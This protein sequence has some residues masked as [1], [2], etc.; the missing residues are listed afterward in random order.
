MKID[1]KVSGSLLLKDKTK[2][3]YKS[4]KLK[5]IIYKKQNV[6]SLILQLILATMEKESRISLLQK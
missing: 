2:S 4:L 6:Y 1:K 5:V 3:S